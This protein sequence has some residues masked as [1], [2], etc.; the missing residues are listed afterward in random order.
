MGEKHR[1]I[2]VLMPSEES[3]L[4][5]LSPS[6]TMGTFITT[7]FA[8]LE[9]SLASLIISSA[10]RLTASTLT[11]P[12]TMEHISSTHSRQGLPVLDISVGLVV[13]P[14]RMPRLW[15]S[16]ISFTSAVSIKNFIFCPPPQY[17]W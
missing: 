14:S 7:F 6:F 13:T 5:A 2:L 11:G 4:T 17:I 16:L 1:V 9:S 12:S 15:A 8:I 10:L 3:T